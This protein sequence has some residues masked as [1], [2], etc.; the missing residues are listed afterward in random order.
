MQGLSDMRGITPQ[1]WSW[2]GDTANGTSKKKGMDAGFER[3][4]GYHATMLGLS[5]MRDITPQCW[6]WRGDTANGISKKRVW[7][8]GLSDMRDITPQCWGWR[9]GH[10]QRYLKKTGMDAGFERHAGYHATV[11]G[12][13][14]GTPPT[15]PK[16]NGY[17]C[18]V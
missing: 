4:A 8:Q 14:V 3:H 11:L 6:S 10:R 15:V 1:C 16:K 13:P 2:R 9:W 17:G 18:R 7:M 5:D 12:L